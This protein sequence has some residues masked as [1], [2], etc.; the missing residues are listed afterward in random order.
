MTCHCTPEL[1]AISP[2]LLLSS[3]FLMGDGIDT[4]PDIQDTLTRATASIT[5]WADLF[6]GRAG[7]HEIL[8]TDQARHGMYLQ[9]TALGYTLS[10]I[11][12]ALGTLNTTP[13]NG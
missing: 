10:A 3:P 8:N 6:T 11:S 9:L 5:L 2:R 4:I 13:R 1:P 7:H 12:N